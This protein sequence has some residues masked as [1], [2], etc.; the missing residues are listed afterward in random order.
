MY[1]AL[2]VL[3]L[4]ISVGYALLSANLRINGTSRINGI[5]WDVHFENAE[6]TENSTVSP[7][8][9]PSAPA[10]S[11]LQTISYD[12]TFDTPGQVY[13][14][15]VDVVNGGT[16]DAMIESFTSKIKIGD[17]EE[18]AILADK[19]NLPAY[20]DYDVTYED[21]TAIAN[22]HLLAAS[23]LETIK[24]TVTFKRDI[25]SAQLEEAANKVITL[26]I[27]FDYKQTDGTEV[28][29]PQ[30]AATTT[31][32]VVS[33]TTMNIGSAIP[34]GVNV[35]STAASAMADWTA[36]TGNST[37][38]PFYLKQVLNGSDE[39]EE[40]Y[41]EFIVSAE[42]AAENEGMV[43]GTYTLKGG[44]SGAAFT[45]NMNTMKTAFDYTNH[46]SRCDGN[47]TSYFNCSVSGLYA[48]A[49]SNG[50]VL[51]RGGGYGC[52]VISD[53]SSSCAEAGL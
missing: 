14:F 26:N 36:I 24:V 7:T 31:G 45:E 1:V 13:E 28:I 22:N 3:A 16:I 33:T 35:R 2:A 32:Y 10:A 53:A 34:N 42:M 47:Q 44:D 40:S 49:Y 21:G 5:T 23:D 48:D 19:S 15:T 52:S 8:T 51:A 20:L 30:P 39:I 11:K 12:V 37:T 17:G 50:G 25:T 43:A 4:M 6:A 18:V 38:Y 29:V 46:S 27:V 9:A 41:V